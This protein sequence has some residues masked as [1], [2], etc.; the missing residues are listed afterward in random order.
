M[1]TASI[2]S[3]STNV[4]HQL[5]AFS[6]I[7]AANSSRAARSSF[8]EFVDADDPR[9]RLQD[10]SGG[11][12]RPRKRAHTGLVHACNGMAAAFP[13]RRLEA[14]HLAEALSFGPVFGA[15]LVN[16]GQYGARSRARVGAQDQLDARL[17][18]SLFDDIALAQ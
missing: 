16:Q 12:D 5:A 3:T 11:G 18:R 8:F 1:L 15:S 2:S 17:Q 6:L 14:K 7:S 10:H 13:K 4:T 9:A